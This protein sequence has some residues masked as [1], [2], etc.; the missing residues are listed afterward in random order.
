MNV[1]SWPPQI[2]IWQGTGNSVLCTF[3]P[4]LQGDYL[5]KL[6]TPR[7]RMT[8]VKNL[9]II[10]Y[11]KEPY[12]HASFCNVLPINHLNAELNPICH[13]LALLGAHHILHVSRM[14]VNVIV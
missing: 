7:I 6:Q 9:V 2:L 1:W 8:A 4:N 13:L 3:F 12:L 11:D 14:R 10:L 5:K